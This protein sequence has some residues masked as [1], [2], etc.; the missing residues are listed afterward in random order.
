MASTRQITGHEMLIEQIQ[1]SIKN[2]KP[3]FIKSYMNYNIDWEDVINIVSDSYNSP[4]GEKVNAGDRSNNSQ[5]NPKFSRF[6]SLKATGNSGLGYHAEDILNGQYSVESNKFDQIKKMQQDLLLIEE[7]NNCI[8]KFAVNMTAGAP[9][10]LPHR[11]T[12]HVLITQVLGQGNYIIHDSVDSDPYQSFV[13][14]AGRRFTE[15]NMEKNDFLFMPYGTI[16]SIDNANL[17]VACIFD[18]GKFK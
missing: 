15:Y 4:I 2:N 1:E 5:Y 7:G 13:D 8:A 18:I 10:L 17:R 16:H 3:L 6:T 14:V 11:D 12:H 9:P